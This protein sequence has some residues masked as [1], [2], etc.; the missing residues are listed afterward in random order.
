MGVSKREVLNRGVKTRRDF[1][2]LGRNAHPLAT[3]RSPDGNLRWAGS[4]H[5]YSRPASDAKYVQC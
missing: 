1:A 3:R 2:E 4:G 5:A